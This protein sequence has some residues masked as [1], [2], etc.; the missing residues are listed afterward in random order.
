[1]FVDPFEEFRRMQERFNRLLE[2]FSRFPEF[3]EYLKEY[4]M[5]MP[6]DVI[7]EGDNI[8]V[9]ADI[10]GFNKEDIEIYFENGDIVIKAERKE[11]VEEKK[12]DY[13]RKERRM[14]RFYRRISLPADINK[15]E[16]KAKYNNGVLEIT[17]PRTKKERKVVPV[18]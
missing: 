14:G 5:G 13:I 9:I 4:R 2:D 18:E 12:R 17:I 15:D 3:K 10:P 16:V 6:V 8:K 7:D 1:M 11:E